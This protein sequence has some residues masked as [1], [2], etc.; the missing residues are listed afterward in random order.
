VGVCT[1]AAYTPPAGYSQYLDITNV[2]N[3][4]SG[5]INLGVKPIMLEP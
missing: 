5:D 3:L 1:T 2:D 4:I